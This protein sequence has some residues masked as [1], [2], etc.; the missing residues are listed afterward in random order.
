MNMHEDPDVFVREGRIHN[1]GS[2]AAEHTIL[3]GREFIANFTPPDYLVHRILQRRYFYSL[4]APTGAGKT[5]I[6][7]R[8]AA[9][10]ELGRPIGGYEV[11]Q[12]QFLY[13]A[14]ENPDDVRM[15]WIAMAEAMEF[16]PGMGHFIPGVFSI[17]ALTARVGHE[18][19]SIGGFA[20]VIVDTSAA[21]FEGEQENDNVSM[22]AHARM[23]RS[24]TTLPSGPTVLALCRPVKNATADN[25]LPRGGGAYAA[26][27]D[28]NLVG[29][30]AD[31]IVE[32]DWQGKFRGPGFEPIA[33]EL[34]SLST[35]KIK[36]SKGRQ[37]PT[38]MAQ[39][40]TERENAA[41]VSAVR[42][43]QDVLMVV[44]LDNE[45]ASIAALAEK[46]K[47]LTATGLPHKSKVHRILTA[48]KRD[49]IV[50]NKRGTWALTEPGKKEAKQAQSNATLAGA[51]YD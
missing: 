43:D 34:I 3:T 18:A 17:P 8:L 46:A 5:A 15:R 44:M 49:R 7:L 4:T 6:A 21:Y 39:P 41:K 35:D 42:S 10:V 24:L 37:I 48:L 45:G 12:G 47:W 23:L 16:D 30:K 27:V 50:D 22:G 1:G 25:L 26:E 19:K 29:R 28:G 2:T 36:D 11:E 40:L 14:G 31:T 33:F 51:K 13:F 20:L 32:L 38:V 9:H